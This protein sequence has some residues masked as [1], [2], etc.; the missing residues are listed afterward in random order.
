MK[1]IDTYKKYHEKIVEVWKKGENIPDDDFQNIYKR[2]A[3]MQ[4]T[5]Y[6]NSILFLGIGASWDEEKINTCKIPDKDNNIQYETKEGRKK[7]PYY[8]K[9]IEIAKETG[10][11][12]CWSSID[13]SLLR[14]TRQEYIE[15]FFKNHL[16]FMQGQFDLA[17]TMIIDIKPK[18]IV[19]NNAFVRDLFKPPQESKKLIES[20]FSFNFD[21]TLGTDRIIA[22]EELKDTP[23]FFTSMLSGQ[24][25]LDNGSYERLKWHINFVLEK[26]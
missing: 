18:I 2:G 25:A 12:E 11:G 23:V 26:I 10:Y 19:V 20:K 17:E 1:E 7:H 4:D 13:M 5:L 6:E 15:P 24:R 22:P 3:F 14:E 16:D 9:M 21:T 8:A